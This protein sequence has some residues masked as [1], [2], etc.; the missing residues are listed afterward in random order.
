MG[1]LARRA[2]RPPLTEPLPLAML[3]SREATRSPSM[4]AAPTQGMEAVPNE[5]APAVF[6]AEEDFTTPPAPSQRR[7]RGFFPQL[8][9]TYHVFVHR[10][11]VQGRGQRRS[12]IRTGWA[13]AL[14][15]CGRRAWRSIASLCVEESRSWSCRWTMEKRSTCDSSTVCASGP[16]AMFSL[17]RS[18]ADNTYLPDLIDLRSFLHAW[19]KPARGFRSF[20]LRTRSTGAMRVTKTR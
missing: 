5:S 13:H 14:L 17:A 4:Q 10:E 20:I 11:R 1:Y 8:H 6:L 16:D 3:S 18:P 12:N 2:C 7:A 15:A 19:P 9:G